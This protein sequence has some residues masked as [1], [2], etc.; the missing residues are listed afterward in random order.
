MALALGA[1]FLVGRWTLPNLA[2]LCAA[3]VLGLIL[4][5]LNIAV[6]VLAA[7]FS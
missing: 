3:G 5:R 4:G 6:A 7:G 2:A 1:A